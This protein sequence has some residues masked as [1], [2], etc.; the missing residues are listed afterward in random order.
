MNDNGEY[1]LA[2]FARGRDEILGYTSKSSLS[3]TQIPQEISDATRAATVQNELPT[4]EIQSYQMENR[5]T[6][7]RFTNYVLCHSVHV[8]N[9]YAL[10]ENGQI[11]IR[12]KTRPYDYT[13]SLL[14]RGDQYKD[15]KKDVVSLLSEILLFE[16]VFWDPYTYQHQGEMLSDLSIQAAEIHQN[17]KRIEKDEREGK[18]FSDDNLSAFLS[19]YW[20]VCSQRLLG[21]VKSPLIVVPASP[22][23]NSETGGDA[24]ITDG[25]RFFH[26]QVLPNL[27][28]AIKKIISVSFGCVGLQTNA[29][30]GTA[31]MMCYPEADTL[32]LPILY[33]LYD[34]NVYDDNL[35]SVMVCVGDALRNKTM[36]DC[37]TKTLE[38][39]LPRSEEIAQDFILYYNETE[40]DEILKQVASASTDKEKKDLIISCTEH[41][42]ALRDALADY[43]LNDNHITWILFSLECKLIQV[44]SKS[45]SRHNA[46]DSDSLMP[47]LHQE[48]ISFPQRSDRLSVEEKE[49]AWELFRK[50]ILNVSDPLQASVKLMEDCSKQQSELDEDA[51][52]K[53]LGIFESLLG[54]YIE[55]LTEKDGKQEELIITCTEHLNALRKALAGFGLDDNG[56]TRILFSLE[57]KLNQACSKP[58][59]RHEPDESDPL[60]AYLYHEIISFSGRS[61]KLSTEEKEM[62]WELYKKAILNVSDYLQASV[63]LLEAC[64]N[65]PSKV[66]NESKIKLLNI[67]ESLQ[68]AY[69]NSTPLA[70]IHDSEAILGEKEAFEKI[71]GILYSPPFSLSNPS[72]LGLLMNLE[73]RIPKACTQREYSL[74]YNDSLYR[75]MLDRSMSLQKMELSPEVRQ[76]LL[77]LYKDAL[78]RDWKKKGDGESNPL[79]AVIEMGDDPELVDS[80]E[81]SVCRNAQIHGEV[82]YD[83]SKLI[84]RMLVQKSRRKEALADSYFELLKKSNQ[85]HEDQLMMDLMEATSNYRGVDREWLQERVGFLLA[86]VQQNN[87]VSDELF[88]KTV[89]WYKKAGTDREGLGGQINDIFIQRFRD[90]LD[91]AIDCV[92]LIHQYFNEFTCS[93]EQ[94]KD[95]ESALTE[96]IQSMTLDEFANQEQYLREL[97]AY[98]EHDPQ[99]MTG[100]ND[101]LRECI[102]KRAKAV[103][104]NTRDVQL[105]LKVGELY[106]FSD[107]EIRSAIVEIIG[108]CEDREFDSEALEE[109]IQYLRT[110]ALPNEMNPMKDPLIGSLLEWTGRSDPDR[111]QENTIQFLRLA[112]AFIQE[113]AQKHRKEIAEKVVREIIPNSSEYLP[114][115]SKLIETLTKFTDINKPEIRSELIKWYDSL[116]PEEKMYETME[117]LAGQLKISPQQV[118]EFPKW[119]RFFLVERAKA[120][121]SQLD[122]WTMEMTIQQAQQP[123]DSVREFNQSFRTVST[124][125]KGRELAERLEKDIKGAIH[126]K[127]EQESKNNGGSIGI[128]LSRA[129]EMHRS[130]EENNAFAQFVQDTLL[131][132]VKEIMQDDS[133]FCEIVRNRE[134][135]NA[136]Q[137]A[138][139][140]KQIADTD[141]SSE[142]R[143]QALDIAGI[144]LETW[145]SCRSNG[146]ITSSQMEEVLQIID[147]NRSA[148]ELVREVCIQEG[149]KIL[150]SAVVFEKELPILI[151]YFQ[152]ISVKGWEFRWMDF[153]NQTHPRNHGMKWED[154]SILEDEDNTY[155]TLASLLSWMNLRNLKELTESFRNFLFDSSIGRNAKT[156]TQRRIK[157]YVRGHPDNPMLKW[158][159]ENADKA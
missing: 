28:D 133:R 54:A 110:H 49:T 75:W 137:K 45:F 2:Q 116:L 106:A 20:E 58:F 128:Y 25:V 43:E 83:T 105:L 96:K 84:D 114:P 148:F 135:I 21:Q 118:V 88:Y 147:Q 131:D 44:C 50:A 70:F 72:V 29:H 32:Q 140:E 144:V 66:D 117:G 73:E 113:N 139:Q 97:E 36:L 124:Q 91:S 71:S 62:A 59:S 129:H 39:G 101:V 127:A 26:D 138:F 40:L 48:L 95:F 31:C 47:F 100:L 154:A 143:R 107:E 150:Q 42:N 41:L 94:R 11:S 64:E 33:S 30:P 1:V 87:I 80:Y 115:N 99:I 65:Q 12:G 27:P 136:F 76:S 155:G 121:R 51:K 122:H 79:R 125:E 46:D 119:N 61:D 10:D 130:R 4:R 15:I 141:A 103:G 134:A 6:G 90:G 38:L 57:C 5:E 120:L 18:K 111:I 145:D 60:M 146:L 74:E 85:N 19:R 55:T 22:E 52:K 126:Y 16:D 149:K 7:E 156:P 108:Q 63:S 24:V 77:I 13:Q 109:L 67:F 9:E 81:E 78:I 112:D 8:D 23:R 153:L 34:N 53:L 98:R 152:R 159:L 68:K 132:F 69:I 35:D 93:N 104:V 37:F 123:E 3:A 82:S 157:K 151:Q 158:L 92:S 89:A 142:L 86:Q 102:R 17:W 14:F 56:I